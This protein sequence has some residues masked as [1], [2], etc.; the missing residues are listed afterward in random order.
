[1]PTQD[2]RHEWE[3]RLQAVLQTRDSSKL[4]PLL[5]EIHAAD[6]ADIFPELDT[7]AQQ[8]V[9]DGL[10][11]EHAAEFLD[12]LDPNERVYVL[13]LLP[14]ERASAILEAMPSDEA[15]DLLA[16]LSTDEAD[17]LLQRMEPELAEDVAD[18]LRY[19]D[20]TAGGLMVKEF[21]RI[22]PEQTVTDVLALLRRH[23]DDA[24][25]IYYLYA[26]DDDDRLLGVVTLRK[27]IICDPHAEIAEVMSREFVS[28]P[29]DMPQDEVA[30]EVRRHDLLAIPVLD[31][32]GRMLGM[33][34]VDD[35][36]DV[37]QEEAA[38][39]LLE[40]SGTEGDEEKAYL[41]STWRGWRNGL[42]SLVGGIVASLLIWYFAFNFA[43][44]K[45]I[46]ALLPLLL[47]LGITAA[48]Q[49]AIAMDRS[50]DNAV[51]R[52]QTSRIFLRELMAGAA[53]ALI[54]SL[55]SG[56]LALIATRR[57]SDFVFVAVPMAAGLW[58]ASAIGA[59]GALLVRRHGGWLGTTSHTIIVVIAFLTAVTI[60][61]LLAHSTAQL[62]LH[63]SL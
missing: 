22:T 60:Y 62:L 43:A 52:H 19:S 54:G 14:V 18:L 23:H 37:V 12:E 36:G 2:R 31:R 41:W 16:E 59:L 42:L 61:L 40:M 27:L 29:V 34:T 35:I 51:E 17:A 6:L 57:F 56:G 53:L 11:D 63:Q 5:A 55:L 26:L 28:V 20:D 8:L 33:V 44:W 15:A 38:E 21:V 1:M 13:D 3:S 48:S 4:I 49:A 10:D 45:Y 25:M 32:D 47:V 9:L 39:E 50:Y 24:E 7:A 46:A 30:E 58:I